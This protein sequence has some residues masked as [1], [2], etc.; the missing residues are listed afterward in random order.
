MKDTDTTPPPALFVA[1]AAPA[2]KAPER[3][4]KRKGVFSGRHRSRVP[5]F[6]T[7]NGKRYVTH[8]ARRTIARDALVE[9][10]RQRGAEADAGR[11]IDTTGMSD[12]EFIAL[13]RR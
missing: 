7:I 10:L 9:R 11:T 3:M 5:F 8:R 1:S 12:Q 6:L 13:L 2:P 4:A